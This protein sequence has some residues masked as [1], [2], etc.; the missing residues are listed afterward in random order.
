MTFLRYAAVF[1]A[2]AL[3]TAALVA[4]FNTQ[5]DGVLGSSAQLLVPAMIAAAVEGHQSASTI[6]KRA[7]ARTVWN[8][9][10]LATL[11]ATG[12]NVA[13]AYL[14]GPFTPEFARLAIAPFLGQQFLVL[15]G[16]YAGAYLVC[17]RLFFAIG[18]GNQ[19]A[20]M[21]SRGEIE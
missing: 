2:V 15:L 1:V 7:D 8:F 5:V 10:W 17:N 14:A 3:G 13:I 20:R 16:L 4:I 11:I 18:Q 9:T 12:L 21:R 6:R 19:L